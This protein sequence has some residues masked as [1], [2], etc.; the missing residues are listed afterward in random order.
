MT[1]FQLNWKAET[2]ILHNFLNGGSGVLHVVGEKVSKPVTFVESTVRSAESRDPSLVTCFIDPNNIVMASPLNALRVITKKLGLQSPTD[3]GRK[4]TGSLEVVKG[5]RS[6]FGDVTITDVYAGNG[7]TTHDESQELSALVEVVLK[8]LG[9]GRRFD[10]LL[11]VFLQWHELEAPMRRTFYSSLWIPVL[12]A[13]V[14][15][16]TRIVFQYSKLLLDP[17]DDTIPAASTKSVV[18]PAAFDATVVNEIAA[19]ALSLGW[20]HTHEAASG[21]AR[22]VLMLSDS[23][24]EVYERLAML[25]LGKELSA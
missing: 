1:A 20:E 17:M 7:S 24:H 13:M 23:V 3:R 19:I 5:V 15:S 8:E 25:N 22:T 11:I 14:E 10:N 4:S 16:G 9:D 2:N 21:L 18:L 12:V 6:L